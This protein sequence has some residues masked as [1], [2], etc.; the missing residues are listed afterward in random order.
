MIL[1]QNNKCAICKQPETA[2]RYG[3]TAN[4]SIDHDHDTGQ[5]R[6]LLCSNCNVMLG[7]FNEDPDLIDKAAAYLRECG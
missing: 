2:T 6:E 1:A 5:L 3:K 4:L 7:M